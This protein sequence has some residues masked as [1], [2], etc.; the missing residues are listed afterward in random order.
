MS[1][2]IQQIQEKKANFFKKF[3]GMTELMSLIPRAANDLLMKELGF[4]ATHPEDLIIVFSVGWAEILKFVS[5]QKFEE[6]AIDICGVSLEYVT[7][8]TES[9]KSSNIVPQMIHKRSPIFMQK[10]YQTEK[11]SKMMDLLN[12]RSNKWRTANLIESQ[13]KIEDVAY[14][15]I[16][17]EYGIQLNSQSMV[18]N[19]LAAMYISGVEYCRYNGRKTVN[20]YNYFTIDLLEDNTI[21]LNPL[22]VIKQSLKN[23]AKK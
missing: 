1:N 10:E 13:D 4:Q 3:D 23:D 16:L 12:A 8:F 18:L 11:G 21:I 5:Q 2:V 20:M 19:I 15:R 17:N 22:A 9:D 7:E 6:Y 14:N